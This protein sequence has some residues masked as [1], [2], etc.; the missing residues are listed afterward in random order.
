VDERLDACVS[1]LNGF[2]GDGL[3]LCDWAHGD[4][5]YRSLGLR[6]TAIMERQVGFWFIACL[7]TRRLFDFGTVRF[8]IVFV[9]SWKKK[10]RQDAGATNS[11]HDC[12]ACGNLSQEFLFTTRDERILT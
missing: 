9:R 1:G 10:R 4:C 2:P 12:V 8:A 6:G 7:R 5:I 11:E 3:S